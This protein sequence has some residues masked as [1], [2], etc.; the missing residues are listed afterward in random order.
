VVFTSERYIIIK[1]LGHIICFSALKSGI[2]EIS[3]AKPR[4]NHYEALSGKYRRN[5][6]F[7]EAAMMLDTIHTDS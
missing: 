4:E 6:R 1:A 7:L 2:G 5:N 3:C